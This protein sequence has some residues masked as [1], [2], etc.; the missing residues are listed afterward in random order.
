[1]QKSTRLSS[2][3][4]ADIKWWSGPVDAAR[5]R[6]G[7]FRESGKDK[8]VQSATSYVVGP[9]QPN[10]SLVE[11]NKEK[12]IQ[13]GVQG[14]S[15]TDLLARLSNADRVKSTSKSIFKQPNKY[16]QI[17]PL[18]VWH[19]GGSKHN[20]AG[21]V[22]NYLDSISWRFWTWRQP[23]A[24]RWLCRQYLESNPGVSK[25]PHLGLPPGQSQLVAL[26][27]NTKICL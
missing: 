11:P 22:V 20:V 8:P 4:N 18:T 17:D 24:P 27:K 2:G 19:C 12:R 21:C 9:V 14:F 25:S 13:K 26:L 5:T 16:G 23:A 1:M 3:T 7:T 15:A 10:R 6:N